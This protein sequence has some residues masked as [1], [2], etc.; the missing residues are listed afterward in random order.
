[1]TFRNENKFV[2]LD[3]KLTQKKIDYDSNYFEV[4]LKIKCR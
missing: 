2:S 4:K 1:M 3:M